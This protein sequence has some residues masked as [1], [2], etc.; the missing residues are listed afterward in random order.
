MAE[1][2]IAYVEAVKGFIVLVLGIV[3]AAVMLG[4]GWICFE[5]I[6]VDL[7]E[8]ELSGNPIGLGVL[9]GAVVIGVAAIV[10][11]AIFTLR[12]RR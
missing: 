2:R 7:I 5:R 10:A 4:V 1:E 9:A 8:K 12:P 11:S 3:L 6:A